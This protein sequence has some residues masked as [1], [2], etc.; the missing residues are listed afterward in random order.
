MPCF[1]KTRIERMLAEQE[2]ALAVCQ[3]QRALAPTVHASS[4]IASTVA[5]IAPTVATIAPTVAA[6]GLSMLSHPL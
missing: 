5:A 1:V 6:T 3:C 2:H 4:A